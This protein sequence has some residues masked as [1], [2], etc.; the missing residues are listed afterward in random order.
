MNIVQKE[1][2]GILMS[3]LSFHDGEEVICRANNTQFG[4]A[5]GIFTNGIKRGNRM[6]HR[7]EVGNIWIDN[8]N[9]WPVELPWR[10]YKDSG[11]GRENGSQDAAFEWT[12]SKS[13]YVEM[14]Q[15]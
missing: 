1:V 4:L 2:F 3:V 5:A 9:L 15:M 12:S 14:G 10:G 6:A 11:V 7:L 13:I 8:Y